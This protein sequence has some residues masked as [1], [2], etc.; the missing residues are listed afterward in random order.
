[1]WLCDNTHF[2]NSSYLAY[3][4]DMICG[5]LKALLLPFL[6]TISMAWPPATLPTSGWL[7]NSSIRAIYWNIINILLS[8]IFGMYWY[9][10]ISLYILYQKLHRGHHL[11]CSLGDKIRM[12][13]LQRLEYND[14]L[15][16]IVLGREIQYF[17]IKYVIIR[18][19][20]QDSNKRLNVS[21]KY[22]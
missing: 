5:N 22:C 9:K 4:L 3:T 14:H 19:D 2:R 20:D 11:M 7:C 18:T 13:Y 1:M 15:M 16:P 12:G 8:E 17:S 21:C 10:H 6:A